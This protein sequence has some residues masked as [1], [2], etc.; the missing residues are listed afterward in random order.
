MSQAEIGNLRVRM[1]IDTAQFAAGV[2]QAQGSLA[3]LMGSLKGLAA[4]LSAVA[5]SS[6]IIG[7]AKAIADI[8]GVA[9]TIG[10]SAEQLQAFQKQAI[11]VG[12]STDSLV[13]GLQ[14]IAEQSVDTSSKLAQLF[15]ANG[16]TVKGKQVNQII[17]EFMEL[18]RNARTPA[19]QLAIM[20]DVLGKRVGRD[21]VEAFREG[22]SGADR[23]MKSMIESGTLH[24]NAEVA[25]LEKL[26]D[27]YNEVTDRIATY[28]QKMIV[29]IVSGI[30]KMVAA[31]EAA[32]AQLP[33][34]E[35]GQIMGRGGRGI[36]APINFPPGFGGNQKE[37]P[38]ISGFGS[39]G[40]PNEFAAVPL[41][42]KITVL[43]TEPEEK[44]KA[45]A[46]V[47]DLLPPIPP[48]TLED[49]Y[50]AGEAVH[51]LEVA[52][53]E[54]QW[55]AGAFSD[56]LL[57]IGD[58]I[59]NSLSGALSGLITGTM[60]V[61]EA[62][63]SMVQ[64]IVQSLADLAAEL[65]TNMA[66]RFLLQALGGGGGAGFNL[67]GMAFGGLY[68]DGGY[69]GSGKWGIAGEAGPEIIHG[70]ARITPMDK[71]GGGGEVSISIN[72]YAGAQVQ[73]RRGANGRIDIDLL[74][75]DIAADLAR[76]GNVIS[77]AVER[78]YGLR[79]AGR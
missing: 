71:M 19:E 27:Q 41:P 54:A 49:I 8:G 5:V 43:P 15:E 1:G 17:R 42:V 61:Q 31:S 74:K 39:T 58:S 78:G 20:T 10:I 21:L 79:R 35:N 53:Q 47:A 3:G 73:T 40:G 48:G 26:E 38:R 16:L 70:P 25:R 65:L 51:S 75:A 7:A 9:S 67:G 56:S 32:A 37:E 60:S 11:A 30:D 59:Q 23:A 63:A 12:A 6:A 34:V 28:W 4:G 52:F 44:E 62:F 55:G 22:S 36:L 64:S 50:G 46:Q 14:S 33:K 2:R 29:G 68:A 76:G 66:F 77:Q 13:K 24:T 18:V 57:S 72:N 45:K 69:L